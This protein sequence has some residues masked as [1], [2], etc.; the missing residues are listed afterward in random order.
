MDDNWGYPPG[1]DTSILCW[2]QVWLSGNLDCLPASQ[3]FGFALR[4]RRLPRLRARFVCLYTK[5]TNIIFF[6]S[7]IST[8][9]GKW[10]NRGQHLCHMSFG[11]FW[12]ILNKSQLLDLGDLLELASPPKLLRKQLGLWPLVALVVEQ[13][14]VPWWKN[15]M[16]IW[17]I[18]TSANNLK[19]LKYLKIMVSYC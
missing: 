14:V 2:Y 16:D 17:T 15:D 10:V 4:S 11:G 18:D 8:P 5:T 13:N 7:C 19:Y 12:G 9:V 3:C 6:L 1:L